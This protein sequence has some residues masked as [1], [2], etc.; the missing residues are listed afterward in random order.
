MKNTIKIILLISV[1]AYLSGSF[2]AASFDITVWKEELRL[3]LVI[4]SS[5]LSLFLSMAIFVYNLE[6]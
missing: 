5:I 4:T 2:L 3:G 1:V 6:I